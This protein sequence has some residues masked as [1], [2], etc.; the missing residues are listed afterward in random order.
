MMRWL[1]LSRMIA[2]R[3]YELVGPA[4]S[5]DFTLDRAGLQKLI[6]MEFEPGEALKITDPDLISDSKVRAEARRGH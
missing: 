4:V 5:Q 3:F 6:D 1:G 2:L